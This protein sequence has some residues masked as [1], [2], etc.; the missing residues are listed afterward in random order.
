MR[1]SATTKTAAE[2]A[3]EI[4]LSRFFASP[5]PSAVLLGWR[6]LA[7]SR[8]E[9][10]LKVAFTAREEFYNPFGLVQ[11]G[12]VSAMLDDT[13]GPLV[14]MLT[15]GKFAITTTDLHVTFLKG[16]TAGELTCEA[17]VVKLGRNV[18]FT[19]A[20]LFDAQGALLARG[21][22]TIFLKPRAP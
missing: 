13:M 4:G 14:G 7:F 2:F 8:E 20:E 1:M 19:E 18:A 22:S 21:L 9:K 17:R 15:E 3:D 10:R 16:A 5:P 6:G 12:I 11:G